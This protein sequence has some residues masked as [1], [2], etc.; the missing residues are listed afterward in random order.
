MSTA[1]DMTKAQ[2]NAACKR[3]G[4]HSVGIMGYYSLPETTVSVSILNASDRRRDQ[5]AYLIQEQI[6]LSKETESEVTA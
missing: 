4:F 6:I 3:H 2:F 5:L 1:E